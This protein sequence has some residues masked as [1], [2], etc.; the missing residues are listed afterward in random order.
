MRAP[1]WLVAVALA[2]VGSVILTSDAAP[3]AGSADARSSTE[4][5]VEVLDTTGR[6]PRACRPITVGARPGVVRGGCVAEADGNEVRLTV[7]SLVGGTSFA[8]CSLSYT[9]H[10]DGDGG[11]ALADIAFAGTA[12]C[13]DI[14]ACRTADDE[15]TKLWMGEIVRRPG[16]DLYTVLDACFTTCMGGF[17]GE[18]E[19]ALQAR[20]G[21]WRAVAR[22]SAVGRS[23]L[24]VDGLWT[25]DGGFAVRPA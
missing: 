19:F 17:T 12:P 22:G 25:L 10:V 4:A 9:M 1:V 13:N 24:V 14:L 8:H 6:R 23:G 2:A 18:L 5:P 15:R 21:A 11:V 3:D 7:D 20:P 16:G